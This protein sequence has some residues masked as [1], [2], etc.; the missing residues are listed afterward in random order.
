MN[1]EGFSTER[2]AVQTIT[3]E[4]STLVGDLNESH[5]QRLASR[6]GH[7][8]ADELIPVYFCA[9]AG[10]DSDDTYNNF[11][12]E[13]RESLTG[14]PKCLVFKDSP[15]VPPAPNE[16]TAFAGVE[17]N[18]KNHLI[19]G[20]CARINV[21]G[22]NV[23]TNAARAALKKILGE[24][25]DPLGKL[26]NEG[27]TLGC[28]FNRCTSAAYRGKGF[29]EIPVF[30][31][32]GNIRS[33]EVR[34]LHLLSAGGFDVVY[35]NPDK[36]C[37]QM[38]NEGNLYS[39]MQ[40]FE[41]PRSK[42][43][44]PYPDK[45]MKAKVATAAYSAER[46]LDTLLYGGDTMFRDFQFS[47][48]ESAVLKTT[49]DEIGILWEQPARFRPGFQVREERAVVPTIFA[50]I[51]GVADGDLNAY[52]DKIEDMLTP[53]TV[54]TV[55]APSYKQPEPSVLRSYDPYHDGHRIFTDKLKTS[56][57]N[58]YG[59]LSDSLQVLIFS[60]LQEA[61]DSGFLTVPD[62]R[63][64]IQYLLYA[65]LNI[66]RNILRILQKYDFT[67]DIPK[68]IVIDA[69]EDTFSLI[70]CVQLVLFSALG[71]DVAV[72]TPTGYRNMEEYIA[73]AAYELHRMNEFKYNVTVPR[74]KIPDKAQ[75]AKK[76]KGLFSGLFKKGRR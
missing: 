44:M 15:F 61:H 43:I 27:V 69:I 6:G 10:Y 22:D 28:W 75:A 38:L 64:L 14:S 68:F 34:L 57:L 11:L 29:S 19:S 48:M 21:Q 33:N 39:R 30:I 17:R 5:S 46:E 8:T 58:P 67:K 54:V 56:R 31:Y 66:D 2:S 37:L 9:V 23:R 16:V 65:G 55:K 1:F 73:P 32:Y 7:F 51:S 49:Y 42:D 36:S 24:S 74:F 63:E 12:F 59:F 47:D 62:E 72:F 26:Y 4:I 53:D 3:A 13:L 18:E 41:L 71:F 50:K 45:E 52:W 20:I 76:K 70:E 35:L 25:S 40:I 60:K